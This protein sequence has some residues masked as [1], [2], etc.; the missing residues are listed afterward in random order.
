L[1]RRIIYDGNVSGNDTGNVPELANT[2][3]PTKLSL[4]IQI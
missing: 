1:E 3:Y 4:S 2:L